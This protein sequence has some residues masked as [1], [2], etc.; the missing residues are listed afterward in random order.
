MLTLSG[1]WLKSGNI[2]HTYLCARIKES[3]FHHIVGLQTSVCQRLHGQIKHFVT[4][5]EKSVCQIFQFQTLTGNALKNLVYHHTHKIICWLVMC[6][7]LVRRSTVLHI[8]IFRAYGMSESA[9]QSESIFKRQA[10]TGSTSWLNVSI[11]CSNIIH[12][13]QKSVTASKRSLAH[14]VRIIDVQSIG[15]IMSS[16]CVHANSNTIRERRDLRTQCWLKIGVKS[17]Y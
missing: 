12:S 7:H 4:V 9:K 2:W 17:M 16:N 3:V 14:L 6:L 11:Q 8:V 15:G 1:W 13:A 10:L 5:R